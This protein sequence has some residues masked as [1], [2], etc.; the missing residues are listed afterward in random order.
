MIRT[1]AALMCFSLPAMALEL[2]LPATARLTAERNTGSD[3]YAAP[4]GVFAQG[5]VPLR[6]VEGAVRRSVWRLD[7][8][9]LTPLQVMRPLRAQLEEAGFDIVLDCPAQTCGGFDFRFAVETLPGPNMYVNIRAFHFVTAMRPVDDGGTDE[10]ITV[11][12]STSTSAAYAQ[13]IQ[14][15]GAGGEAVAV[16][17]NA[18]V[19]RVSA[20]VV[21]TGE[22]SAVL[23]A[24]GHVVLEGLEFET[25]SAELG[26]GPFEALEQVAAFL[27]AQPDLRVALVG[28]TD[29]VG[30]LS[31]NIALSKRRAQSVRQRLIEAHGIEAAR[32]QAEGMG[33]LAPRA[34]NLAE[35]GRD[36]NRRVE[37]ILLGAE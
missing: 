23:L 17:T 27:Q 19:P 15:G 18:D 4:I 11:L 1:L 37:V 13:I 34:S 33:Y 24:Q 9:G 16:S 30:S 12:T 31:G 10:V 32:M 3:I 26:P 36:L 22:L 29:S 35:E 28:H 8:P 6:N 7:S 20:P 2:T 14:A 21:P 25:G 5:A